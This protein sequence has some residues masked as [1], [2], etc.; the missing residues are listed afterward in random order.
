MGDSRRL[1]WRNRLLVTGTLNEHAPLRTGD[2]G[3]TTIPRA[4]NSGGMLRRTLLAG[5]AVVACSGSGCVSNSTLRSTSE[6]TVVV[7]NAIDDTVEAT[8]RF[9]IGAGAIGEATVDLAADEQQQFTEQFPDGDR[10]ITIEV[11]VSMPQAVT[12]EASVPSGVPEYR[13]RIQSS[14]IEVVWAEN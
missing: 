7:T 1:P 5:S 4:Q 13:V 2:T 6:S 3:S 12:H 9:T 8:L 14:D 10:D 11:S